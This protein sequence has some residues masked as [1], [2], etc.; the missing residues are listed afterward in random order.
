MAKTTM[1]NNTSRPQQA[2]GQA[3]RRP[4]AH[5]PRSPRRVVDSRGSSARCGSRWARSRGLPRRAHPVHQRGHR[6]RR[7]RCRLHRPSRPHLVEPRQLRSR[8]ARPVKGA[9]RSWTRKWYVINTYSGHENKARAN[10]EH[11]IQ[12]MN[13]VSYFEDIVVPTEQVIETKGGEKVQVEKRIFPG[14]ILVK[15]VLTDDSWSLV[16]NTPGVTGFVGLGQQA[17]PAEPRRGRPHPPHLHRREAQGQGRVL[18]GRP[19][20]GDR[21][22]R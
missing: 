11:R 20:A 14:Y 15:M 5:A 10:L 21:A 7:H 13:Q 16:K 1:S 8:S 17:D 12:S 6:G 2:A 3:G 19:G 22:A 4:S 9:S 18:G